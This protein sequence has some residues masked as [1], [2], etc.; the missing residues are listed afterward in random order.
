M[1]QSCSVCLLSQDKL[2]RV[3]ISK[4]GDGRLARARRP[5]QGKPYR[6]LE[7][8]NVNGLASTIMKRHEQMQI[9]LNTESTSSFRTPPR[10]DLGCSFGAFTILG[11]G[12][13]SLPNSKGTFMNP[14]RRLLKPYQIIPTHVRR[15]HSMIFNLLRFLRFYLL[16]KTY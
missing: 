15:F 14:V 12:G 7:S 16:R 1:L 10:Q 5:Y 9:V 11:E 3:P 2:S 4:G 13:L 6:S 8:S